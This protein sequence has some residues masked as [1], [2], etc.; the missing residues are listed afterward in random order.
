MEDVTMQVSGIC[1]KDGGKYAHVTFSCEGKYAR[2]TIPDCRITEHE[3][4]TEEEAA[5]LELFMKMNLAML[6]RQA[7]AINPLRAMMKD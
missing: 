1:R 7:A 4:F 3:G 6:K 5:Q 2:G